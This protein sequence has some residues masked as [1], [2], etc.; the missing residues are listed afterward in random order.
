MASFLKEIY[1]L[2]LG[3]VGQTESQADCVEPEVG[4]C[5]TR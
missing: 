4:P 2:T 5:L 1:L 3:A